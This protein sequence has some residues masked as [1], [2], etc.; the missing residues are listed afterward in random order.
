MSIGTTIKKLRK[1]KDFTQEQLAEYLSISP[2]AIS[3]WETD[4]SAPD[5]YQIPVLARIFNVS[6]DV[7]L[8]INT[9][10]AEEE[11]REFLKTY[12]ELQNIGKKLEAFDLTVAMYNKYPSDFRVIEKYILELFGDPHYGEEPLGEEVH[13]EEIEKLCTLV[14]RDCTDQQIR[15]NAYSTMMVIYSNR[16][17]M[18]SAEKLCGYFPE[19]SYDT[20][21]ELLEQ[22][23]VRTDRQLYAKKSRENI[24]DYT[25]VLVQKLWNLARLVISDDADRLTVY[26]KSLA[27][28]ELIHE[29]EEIGYVL[30]QKGYA[31]SEIARCQLR[32]GRTDEGLAYMR[33]SFERFAAY[34]RIALR[35]NKIETHRSLVLTGVTQD[36]SKGWHFGKSTMVEAHLKDFAALAESLTLPQEFHDI[37]AE[38]A[39]N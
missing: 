30:Y 14:I 13:K 38:Y 32:L 29:D 37:L 10:A 21:P 8:E 6:A 4:K 15:Y 22:L 7:I 39:K 36:L 9:T 3:Q 33:Q 18:K 17:D 11:I 31:C 35:E 34:D 23:Y 1:E 5:V 25:T 12:A 28:L 19:S 16:G 20:E 2:Q 27:L 24:A 26:Q